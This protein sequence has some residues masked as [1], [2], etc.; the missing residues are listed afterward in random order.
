MEAR[1]V[2]VDKPVLNTVKLG[3][4]PGEPVVMLHGWGQSL[5]SLRAL[6]EL[7]S[8]FHTVYLV[9][10]PGFG[11]SDEP[12]EDADTVAYAEIIRQFLLDNNIE[13][14][15]LLGHSFGGRVSIRLSSRYPELVKSIILVDSGGLKRKVAGRK[16]LRSHFI[17]LLSKTTKLLD[18]LTG[19][20][21][22]K[23]WFTPKFG[24]RDY[25]NSSGTMRK[26]LV[27]AVNEDVT[28]DAQKVSVPTFILWGEKD[29]ETPVEM[30]ERLNELIKNSKL[31]VLPGKDHFPFL[32]DGAHLCAHH[33]LAFLKNL[34]AE[35]G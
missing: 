1:G 14:P 32:N 21:L 8:Q 12:D 19:S 7:V 35:G 4:K 28:E 3:D 18:N 15:H 29:D 27:R 11:N 23:N 26:V 20:T 9:D 6:G 22:F 2:L 25:L 10:L 34:K 24:S 16:K 33:L 31:T 13:K 17:K 30:G 5:E